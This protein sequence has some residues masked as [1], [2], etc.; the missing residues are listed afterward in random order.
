M[1]LPSRVFRTRPRWAGAV[2]GIL[3]LGMAPALS[4]ASPAAAI[5]P[6]PSPGPLTLPA[7]FRLV[8]EE[9]GQA[10]YDFTDFA[11]LPDGSKITTGKSGKLAWVSA[12]QAVAR[13]IAQLPVFGSNDVGLISVSI[14]PDYPTSG[15]LYLLYPQAR[16]DGH[17]Y[18]RMARYTVDNPSNPTSVSGE[19]IILDNIGQDYPYHGPGTVIANADGTFYAGFGDEGSFVSPQPESLRAQDINDP[20]GK[21]FRFDSQGRGLP[22]NPFYDPANPSSWRSRVFAYGVRNPTRFTVD[23]RTG[24][25]YIGDV[26]WQ[27]WEEVDVASGGENFGWPC[28]EGQNIK[29]SGYGNLAGC[30]AM[31]A[32]NIRHDAPLFAWPHNGAGA[33]AIGGMFYTGVSYPAVYRGR[34]FFADY[35]QGV[36]RMIGTDINDKVTSPGTLFASGLGAP[37]AIHPML[38]GDLAYADILTGTIQRLRYE[39]GNRPPTAAATTVNNPDTLTVTVD[40]TT[41]SDLDGDALTYSINF[42]DGSAPATTAQAQHIYAAAGAYSVTVT[43][44]DPLGAKDTLTLPVKPANHTPDL[45]LTTPPAGQKFAVGSAVNVSATATDAE[46]G[47]L[48]PK[49]EIVLQHCPFGGVCHAHPDTTLMG[50]SYSGVFTEH[51]GDTKMAI[52]VSV[53]D[54]D[55]ATVS[56]IYEAL[57]D[58]HTL[59]VASPAPTLINN[60]SVLSYTAVAGQQVSVSVPGLAAGRQFAGWSDGGLREHTVTMPASNLLLTAKYATEIE[61]KYS[62]YGGDAVLGAATSAETGYATGALAGGRYRT[63]AGGAILWSRTTGAH[64]VRGSLFQHYWEPGNANLYGFPTDDEVKMTTGYTSSFERGREYWSGGSGAHFVKGAIL[65]R[66]LALGGPAFGYPITDEKKTADGTGSYSNF[67]NN[68]S[69]Y[70]SPLT[71]AWDVR[72]TLRTKYVLM[73]GERSCLGYPTS[74]EYVTPT[75]LRNNFQRGYITYTASTKS[76]VNHCG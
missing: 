6:A 27:L 25:L 20:H 30:Q 2:A 11:V 50:P 19:K 22:A 39:S 44:T 69:V 26:G 66:Y 31:Y 56:K 3:F 65:T 59:T 18:D 76:T 16:A 4:L 29:T 67:T 75:G 68:R 58:V 33:A 14:A 52:T 46:D 38:N 73:G 49:F 8:T 42:G 40:A 10:R 12:D 62:Q 1:P 28:Y 35:A 17:K 23:A 53:T 41:S 63:Y 7:G 34:Y 5:A 37:V 51:G 9:S 45:Q 64:V 71:G 36:L 61:T 32:N 15:N 48:T 47:A 55:G 43:V 70:W 74:G 13:T 54:S 60:E 57:P 72:G 24:R 21:I